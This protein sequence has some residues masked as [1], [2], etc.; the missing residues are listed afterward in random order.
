MPD[1]R[2]PLPT[3][4]TDATTEA[5]ALFASH[6]PVHVGVDIGKQFHKLVARGPDGIR[7]AAQHV[8]VSR[9]GF[10]AADGYLQSAIFGEP[11]ERMLVGVEHA[12][13]YG[14]TFVEFLTRLGYRVVTV[15][16]SVTKRLKEVEDNSPQKDDAKDARQIC[17]LVGQGLFLGAALLPEDRVEL[18]LLVTERRRLTRE[19]VGLKNRL[20]SCLDLAW[21][22]FFHAFGQKTKG[23]PTLHKVTPV[24]LIRRWPSAHALAAAAPRT[25]RTFV[26]TVSRNHISPERVDALIATARTSVA[27][28]TAVSTREAE[29]QRLLARWDL[30]QAQERVIDARLTELIS[31]HSGA[32]ALLTMPEV[33]VVCAATLL[34][35]LGTP[36]TFVAPRQVLKLAGMNLAGRSSG[37]S[38]RG[39]VRQTKRGRPLLRRELYLLAGRWCQTRG[40]AR[41]LYHRMRERG[42]PKTAAV[43]AVARK[44]VPVVLRLLKTGEAFDAERW[45]RAHGLEPKDARVRRRAGR[46]AATSGMVGGA[47]RSGRRPED[48]Q[49]FAAATADETMSLD[50]RG[51]EPSVKMC[52]AAVVESRRPPSREGL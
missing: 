24:A 33:S 50:A 44:L 31:A 51:P 22:E 23:R 43:C 1:F 16:P 3:T 8:A 7:Q 13:S 34:A 49:P 45:Q 30:V 28:T 15:L 4:W 17:H 35:E 41:P 38:V 48:P 32:Q 19:E 26:K 40:L 20:I 27:L 42:M 18:R 25:V 14:Q 12:G 10:E 6:F 29:I 36:E 5:K 47:E 46:G 2:T 11:R 9:E 21:P 39:R 52:Q 37:I